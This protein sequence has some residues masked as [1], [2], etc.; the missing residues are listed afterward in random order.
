MASDGQC[1][2]GLVTTVPPCSKIG[3][4]RVILGSTQ[5]LRCFERQKSIPVQGNA[6]E[7][8]LTEKKGDRRLPRKAP[9]D[10]MAREFCR[11]SRRSR[12]LRSGPPEPGKAFRTRVGIALNG[13]GERKYRSQSPG[14]TGFSGPP[15]GNGAKKN[16]EA[17]L[18]PVE[19][20]I[21]SHVWR[22]RT[23]LRRAHSSQ[24]DL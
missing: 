8:A 24:S 14:M 5:N 19:I 23:A 2:S 10:L 7:T 9:R 17:L 6:R 20:R 18:T 12:P 22:E 13:H 3:R 4:G 1:R 21:Q 16:F 11:R 15:S